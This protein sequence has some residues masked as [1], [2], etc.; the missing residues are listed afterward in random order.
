MNA[1]SNKALST[2]A[3]IGIA[4]G[5]LVVGVA[6]GFFTGLSVGRAAGAPVE[7][8]K[9]LQEQVKQLEEK[10]K[11]LSQSLRTTSVVTVT[12]FPPF[13]VPSFIRVKPGDE[14]RWV[15]SG[16]STTHTIVGIA[17]PEPINSGI[18]SGVFT[19]KL[20]KEGVH[21]VVC[22]VHPYMKMVI[23]VGDVQ[24]PPEIMKIGA[25]TWPP[26]KTEH[27][28]LPPPA[29][30]GEGIVI[31]DTQFEP[32]SGRP[33]PGTVTIIDAKTWKVV[34]VIDS[35][36][37][38]NPHNPWVTPDNRY[39]WQTNW[40][41]KFVSV[42]DLQ[43][44]SIVKEK[45]V[46]GESPAHVVITPDG[47]KAY[48]SI[49]GESEMA[50]IDTQTYQVVKKVPVGQGPHAFHMSFRTGIMAIAIALG[51][52]LAIYD[53]KTDT[54]LSTVDLPEPALPLMASMSWDGK[55]AYISYIRLSP[56]ALLQGRV[57]V[58]DVTDPKNPRRVTVIDVGAG[59]IQVIES[60]DSKYIAV[61]NTFGNSLSIIERDTWRVKT[62]P[63]FYGQHGVNFG[64]KDKSKGT[65]Y[66]YSSAKF[67]RV[68]TVVGG[69]ENGF[70]A[71]KVVGH[72]RLHD[73][74]WGGNGILAV[75]IPYPGY[76]GG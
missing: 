3:A 29:E 7:Q 73:E 68:V 74:A 31:V 15:F 9:T 49:N 2:G 57:M 39:L 22:T 16:T 19:T 42:I 26:D 41:D 65:Y 56:D 8:L 40:H 32:V 54:L 6:A 1:S 64:W 30:P 27:D 11:L 67:A 38:N 13:F 61:A 51:N 5:L 45:I 43:T 70:D 60:P 46:V 24:V 14:V 76:Y 37:F 17:G 21:V 69:F 35:P 75:P 59:P 53:T 4:I 50:V 20:T 10:N 63:G 47:K 58:V 33:R 66:L 34:K 72:I 23:A 48:V 44:G 52:K 71:I 28:L 18:V 36:I 62:L 12:D 55:Y 25:T